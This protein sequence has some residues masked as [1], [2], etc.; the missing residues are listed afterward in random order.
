MHCSSESSSEV[1]SKLLILWNWSVPHRKSGRAFLLRTEIVCPVH[2]TWL[3]S[4]ACCLISNAFCATCG[5]HSQSLSSLPLWFRY[6]SCSDLC[7][8][9][10]I[11]QLVSDPVDF[12]RLSDGSLD[13][14]RPSPNLSRLHLLLHCRFNSNLYEVL[15]AFQPLCWGLES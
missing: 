7:I 14:A 12:H 15:P 9:V 2:T 11:S 6:A 8:P 13:P 4:A 5:S 10:R 1:R 3:P